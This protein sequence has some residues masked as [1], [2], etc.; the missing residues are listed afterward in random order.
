MDQSGGDVYENVAAAAAADADPVQQCIQIFDRDPE[1]CIQKGTLQLAGS[2]VF[3]YIIQG[4]YEVE[5]VFS[6]FFAIGSGLA[7]GIAF[8]FLPSVWLFNKLK[9]KGV[10]LRGISRK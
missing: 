1:F 4:G 6:Y 8:V 2:Q 10:G 7:L 5:S 3:V 9:T